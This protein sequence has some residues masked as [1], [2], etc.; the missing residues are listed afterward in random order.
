MPSKIVTASTSVQSVAAENQVQV[1]K[2]TSITVDNSS[3]SGDRQIIVQDGFTPAATN[4]DSSPSAQTVNR[5]Q[6]VIPVGDVVTY[7]E[8]DLEGITC[9]GSLGIIADAIDASCAVSVGYKSE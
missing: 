9:L 5:W 6:A 7:N 3:G 8:R 4:G 2:P 1:H